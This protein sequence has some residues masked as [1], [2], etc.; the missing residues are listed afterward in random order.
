MAP[1]TTLVLSDSASGLAARLAEELARVRTACG[2]LAP[3]ELLVPHRAMA[4]WLTLE[5]TARTGGVANLRFLT[6][7]RLLAEHG[8]T[9]GGLTAEVYRLLDD[10]TLASPGFEGVLAYIHRDGTSDERRK[11]RRY[12]LAR[13]VAATFAQYAAHLPG[14][15]PAPEDGAPMARWQQ[16]LWRHLAGPATPTPGASAGAP[17]FVFDVAV[18]GADLVRAVLDRSE[19]V[20]VFAR[21]SHPR[22]S[23]PGGWHRHGRLFALGAQ[24]WRDAGAVA[25]AVA[26]EPP[27]SSAPPRVHRLDAPSV[28]RG[29]EAVAARIWEWVRD[30]NASARV[31]FHEVAVV[32]PN[33]VRETLLPVL[34][35]VFSE[36]HGLPKVLWRS[37]LGTSNRVVALARRLV[38]LPSTPMRRAELLE[39]LTHPHLAGAFEDDLPESWEDWVDAVGIFHGLDASSHEGTYLADAAAADW[40]QGL[41]RLALGV[42]LGSERSGEASA[43]RTPRGDLVAEETAHSGAPAVGRFL[44]LARSLLS[45]ADFL[46]RSTLPAGEWRSLL[47]SYLATYVRPEG[48]QDLEVRSAVLGA[49]E[50]FERCPLEGVL[51]WEVA[52]AMVLGALDAL[53][54]DVGTHLTQ[55]IVVGSPSELRGLPFRRLVFLGLEQGGYPSTSVLSEL[56]LRPDDDAGRP[57]DPR[58]ADALAFYDLVSST[59]GEVCLVCVALDPLSGEKRAPSLL[60][61]DLEE[62][63]SAQT[64]QPASVTLLPPQRREQQDEGF[65]WAFPEAAVERAVHVAGQD[66]SPSGHRFPGAEALPDGWRK[67][68]GCLP[69]PE[70]NSAGDDIIDVSLSRLVRFLEYPTRGYA[71]QRLGYR[72]GEDER[73]DLIDEPFETPFLVST[74]LQREVLHEL[75]RLPGETWSDDARLRGSLEEAYDRAVAQRRLSGSLPE[76]FFFDLQR[77]RDLADLGRTCAALREQPAFR[78]PYRGLRWGPPDGFAERA[79][80][81]RDPLDLR[82]EVRGVERTVRLGGN[83]QLLSSDGSALFRFKGSIKI[84]PDWARVGLSLKHGLSPWVEH[85]LLQAAGERRARVSYGQGRTQGVSHAFADVAPEVARDRL[86][87]LLGDLLNDRVGYRCPSVALFQGW[88]ELAPGMAWAARQRSLRAYEDGLFGRFGADNERHSPVRRVEA[89]RPPSEQELDRVYR[90]VEPY[91]TE[92]LERLAAEEAQEKARVDAEK[93]SRE[94]RREARAV[95]AA[96]R[97]PAAKSGKSGKSA[98]PLDRTEGDAS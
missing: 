28:R 14:G 57:D 70:K 12:E 30:D 84:K 94:A 29:L 59:E 40:D 36:A 74:S 7:S 79:L 49:L 34:R 26:S 15:P 4:E 82:V 6:P 41:S 32:V 38:E 10:E 17:L 69:L 60:V 87:K 51:P 62:H 54:A 77:A 73:H 1:Q 83:G 25:A 27:A 47:T 44:Q 52:R 45:D 3:V 22:A 53:Q 68:I 42:F 39:V 90:R 16:E 48:T 8:R 95:E 35:E 24:R 86:G 93:A 98:M 9:A 81:R 66:M 71:E 75:A 43:L 97:K 89:L 23:E 56:D 65:T 58:R 92:Q 11:L 78:P 55:G 64:K 21:R 80:E 19:E 67:A 31:R 61:R 46:R 20:R 76:G 63:V 37:P 33:G 5:L 91:A 85:L 96:A 88:P 50:V 13:R 2:P 72:A 18:P